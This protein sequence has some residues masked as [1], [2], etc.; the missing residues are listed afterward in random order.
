MDILEKEI[1]VR[2]YLVGRSVDYSDDMIYLSSISSDINFIT[3]DLDLE[4]GLKFESIKGIHLINP[5]FP[6]SLSGFSEHL[7]QDIRLARRIRDEKNKA[8]EIFLSEQAL[9]HEGKNV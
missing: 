6:K 2:G 7:V 1:I 8:A 3:F 5:N 4:M 9:N